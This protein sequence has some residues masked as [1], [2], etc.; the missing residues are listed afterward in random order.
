MRQFWYELKRDGPKKTAIMMIT[1]VTTIPNTAL[2]SAISILYIPPAV[3][4]HYTD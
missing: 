2:V 1:L 4:G 3:P